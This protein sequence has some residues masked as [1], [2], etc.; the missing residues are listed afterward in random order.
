MRP[1]FYSYPS[2]LL[3]NKL[4]KVVAENEDIYF[5]GTVWTTDAP[6]R[7]T[8]FKRKLFLEKGAICVDMEA[9]SLFSIAKF[10]RIKIACIFYAG[11]LV[12]EK[13]DLRISNN[14]RKGMKETINKLLRYSIDTLT[15]I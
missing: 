12:D 1:S 8:R 14:Y 3:Y 13:W 5:K 11:D 7:E 4:K 6:Y 9:A 2:K 15:R 10:R